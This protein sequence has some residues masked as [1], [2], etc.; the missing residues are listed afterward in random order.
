MEDG[1]RSAVIEE[2]RTERGDGDGTVE[3]VKAAFE[4]AWP[5]VISLEALL[6]HVERSR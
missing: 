2:E 5:V 4:W 1:Q 6:G 3:L